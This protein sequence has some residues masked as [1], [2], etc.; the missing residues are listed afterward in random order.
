ML[1]L[2]SGQVSG[3]VIAS[4]ADTGRHVLRLAQPDTAHFLTLAG[5]DCAVAPT[6]I[7]IELG[8]ADV[9]YLRGATAK[10]PD[11][12]IRIA[13]LNWGDSPGSGPETISTFLV[14]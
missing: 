7:R 4:G 11:E 1:A 12:M 8:D 10:P 3:E 13:H 14:R 9:A 6:E 2:F 5:M